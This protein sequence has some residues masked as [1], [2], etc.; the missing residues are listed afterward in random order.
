MHGGKGGHCSGLGLS[1][2]ARRDRLDA[3]CALFSS[4]PGRPPSRYQPA[5]LAVTT[6]QSQATLF[7]QGLQI[8]GTSIMHRRPCWSI[9]FRRSKSLFTQC[10][11]IYG[12]RETDVRH[13]CNARDAEAAPASHCV[14]KHTRIHHCCHA[15][16]WKCLAFHFTCNLESSPP[17]DLSQTLQAE[18]Y[19]TAVVADVLKL[20]LLPYYNANLQRMRPSKRPTIKVYCS[21]LNHFSLKGLFWFPC[22]IDALLRQGCWN[23]SSLVSLLLV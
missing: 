10:E 4:P 5:C 1:I 18:N 21:S 6:C 3:A 15:D 7:A 11:F 23:P 22:A 9:S 14:Q 8:R 13:C 2:P 19:Y 12:R 17:V 20:K 16:F